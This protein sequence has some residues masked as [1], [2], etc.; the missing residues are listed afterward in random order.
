M[1]LD[2]HSNTAEVPFP[3]LLTEATV[4][5]LLGV[6]VRHLQN[7]RARRQIRYIRLGHA[8]RVRPDH[9]AEDISKLT[10]AARSA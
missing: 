9:L 10:V 6:S 8:I 3:P 1:N 7:L 5:E 2:S 4:S